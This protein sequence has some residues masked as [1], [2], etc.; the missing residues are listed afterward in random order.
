MAPYHFQNPG[1]GYADGYVAVGSVTDLTTSAHNLVNL[2]LAPDYMMGMPMASF[3]IAINDATDVRAIDITNCGAAWAA[4][5]LTRDIYTITLQVRGGNKKDRI[6]VITLYSENTSSAPVIVTQ[7]EFELPDRNWYPTSA[8]FNPSD[9]SFYICGF[10]TD[11]N[12]AGYPHEPLL[13]DSKSAFAIVYSLNMAIQAGYAI[14]GHFYDSP[15]PTNPPPPGV[16]WN[17]LYNDYDVAQHIRVKSGGNHIF[18]T[19]S[20]NGQS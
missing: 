10:A 19:G 2:V 8:D 1:G 13:T 15:I 14:Y 7:G 20:S 16:A 5:G 9:T 6:E 12:V 17:G 4:P 3:N 18:M 11:P